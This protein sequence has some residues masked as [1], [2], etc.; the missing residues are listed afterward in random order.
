LGI[1]HN[2]PLPKPHNLNETKSG[3]TTK[4]LPSTLSDALKLFE[5]SSLMREALGD[6]LVDL[7]VENKHYELDQ[8]NRYITDY[9]INTYLP[10][11]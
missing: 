11:L 6:K 8:Y 7:F 3:F 4:S 10:I 5:K 9:E 1:E 2:E